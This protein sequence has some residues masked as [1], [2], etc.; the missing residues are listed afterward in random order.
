MFA[1]ILTVSIIK[2]IQAFGNVLQLTSNEFL[3]ETARHKVVK[4]VINSAFAI[5]G[6]ILIF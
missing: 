4:I 6:L 2:L 5:W 3:A 1:F